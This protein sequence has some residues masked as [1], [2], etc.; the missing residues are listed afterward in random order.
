MEKM[1]ELFLPTNFKRVKNEKKVLLEQKLL[2]Q[3]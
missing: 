3:I 2:K 1:L